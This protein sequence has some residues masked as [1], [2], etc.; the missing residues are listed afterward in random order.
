[1]SVRLRLHLGNFADAVG[2]RLASWGAADVLARMWARDHT[3]WSA[4]PVPE[5]TD[6]LGW[7]E[8][9]DR[10]TGLVPELEE[11]GRELVADGI[12]HVVVLGMGG[13]SLAPEVFAKTFGTAPDAPD[14]RVLDSTH[15]AAVLSTAAAIDMESTGFIVASK[16][17]T[18]IEPLSFMEYFWSRVSDLDADPGRR[19]VAIT[20]PGSDLET[21][22]GD[23]GFRRT[24]LAPLDVGGRYSALTEFGMV[25]AA[26]IGADLVALG[27]SAMSALE[28]NGATAGVAQSRGCRLGAAMGELARAGRD[29]VTFLTSPDLAAFPAWIE[30][31]IAESTGKSGTG[32]V[33]VGGEA[34]G[35]T[36]S[37][38]TDRFFVIIETSVGPPVDTTTIAD[39]P[40]AEISLDSLTDI[41][42]AMYDFEVA[43]AL[44]GSVLRIQPFNQ[45]DV[46]LAKE[47]ARDAMAGDLDTSNVAAVDALAPDLV[48][49]VADWL[50]S[51]AAGDYVGI[52]AFIEPT[53]ATR[54][55]LDEARLA[56]RDARGLAT[57]V[58]FG[59][60]FLH[61][62][63]QLHKGG[64]DSGLFLEIIDHPTPAVPVPN[65]D[66]DFARLV[67]AQAL[68][69]HLALRR[70]GRRI[71]LISLG[72][73]GMEALERVCAAVG[74]A[75]R[76][77][78]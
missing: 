47:L 60:R 24:F 29:K 65:T 4:Q 23:R 3:L 33:P 7:L 77:G 67:T 13:S 8:L 9:P 1:M 69:D 27:A 17:G 64:P 5:L 72:D 75:A 62:T 41:A 14:L 66:Y 44:A 74:A 21:L 63:G 52:H 2:E 68:G 50:N 6:R 12:E 28:N 22:A 15:P 34:L 25:P 71:L 54:D 46:Q 36:A 11:F 56:V 31:L 16:S 20:D 30:Q 18:T 38:G 70:K 45:P 57:T 51:A 40:Y 26:A 32:I 42:G 39:H 53:T 76:S 58:D 59:P 55:A 73:S 10:L 48:G 78:H 37:Y 43:T 35:S 61:S 19:F 49:Q